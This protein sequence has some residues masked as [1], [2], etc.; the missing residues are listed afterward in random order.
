MQLMSRVGKAEQTVDEQFNHLKTRLEGQEAKVK[1]LN[2]DVR[3]YL[4]AL[5]G[6][7]VQ[8]IPLD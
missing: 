5:K 2:V 6:S 8:I 7:S 3:R 4:D 1:K